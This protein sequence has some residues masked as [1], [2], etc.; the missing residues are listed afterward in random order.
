MKHHLA[1]NRYGTLAGIMT[2]RLTLRTSL[3]FSVVEVVGL[4]R[5]PQASL[6]SIVIMAQRITIL[7][8]AQCSRSERLALIWQEQQIE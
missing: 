2:A 7:G 8:S 1:K 5:P 4:I 6:R 3:R